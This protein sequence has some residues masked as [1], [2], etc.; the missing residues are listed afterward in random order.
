MLRPT[1]SGRSLH[2][3]TETGSETGSD[4]S[5]GPFFGQKRP[6]NAEKGWGKDRG[7]LLFGLN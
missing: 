3:L 1:G 4:R 2:G 6:K 5:R 7:V